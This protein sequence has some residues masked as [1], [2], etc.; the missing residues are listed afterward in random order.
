MSN[1][2]HCG[3]T[4]KKDQKKFCSRSCS[5]SH[6]NIGIRR[7]GQAQNTNSCAVCGT[8]TTNQKFCSSKCFGI[9]KHISK[10]KAV[11]NNELAY[12]RQIKTYLLK[13]A[14]KCSECGISEWNNK[15]ISLE[16]DHIDGDITNNRLSNARLLC[17]NCHSQTPTFRFKNVNNPNGREA[18]RKRYEQSL[19]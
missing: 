5:A 9:E 1:C 12:W 17:P 2:T 16:C 11:V 4:L 14:F 7:H 10:E 6:N 3:L 19:K 13:T 15:P 18:R 8:I